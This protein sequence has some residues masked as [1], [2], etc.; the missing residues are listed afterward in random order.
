MLEYCFPPMS[1]EE[2]SFDQR[3]TLKWTVIVYLTE[4]LSNCLLN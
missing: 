3:D 1:T 2:T 4:Y